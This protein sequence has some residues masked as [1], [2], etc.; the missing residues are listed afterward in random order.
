MVDRYKFIEVY[1]Y[2][3]WWNRYVYIYKHRE[4]DRYIDCIY[5]YIHG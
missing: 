3:I 5:G 4:V 2:V 1:L